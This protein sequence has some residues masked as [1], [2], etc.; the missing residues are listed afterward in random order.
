MG[1]WLEMRPRMGDQWKEIR[2]EEM[3]NEFAWPSPLSTLK[4][5]GVNYEENVLKFHEHARTK[6]VLSPSHAD[7]KK[8]IYRSAV[9][10][11]R[12]Y[13]KYLEPHLAGLE[14]FIR[15]FSYQ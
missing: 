15:A 2:Y 12:H 6:R 13:Q 1:F 5:L 14:P 9:G 11:W 10:R 3:V 8:P 4:F 7:V